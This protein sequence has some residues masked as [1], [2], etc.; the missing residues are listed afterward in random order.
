MAS[1]ST[2]GVYLVRVLTDDRAN[3]L[4]VAAGSSPQEAVSLVLNA[5]PEGWSASLAQ[6]GLTPAEVEGLN[7]KHGEVHQISH[8]IRMS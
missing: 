5:I 3:E 7:L 6:E 2:T 4:W 8:T 1:S